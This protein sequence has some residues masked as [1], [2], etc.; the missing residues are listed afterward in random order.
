MDQQL[1]LQVSTIV[2]HGSLDH[3][4]LILQTHWEGWEMGDIFI[5]IAGY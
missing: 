4:T 2:N 5:V 3:N 1:L